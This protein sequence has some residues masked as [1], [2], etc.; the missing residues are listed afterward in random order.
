MNTSKKSVTTGDLNIKKC[1]LFHKSF[2]AS[3]YKSWGA[4]S[5]KV[6]NTNSKNTYATLPNITTL[7]E[8][9]LNDE[10]ETDSSFC[11]DNQWLQIS[12]H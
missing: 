2:S 8:D 4:I 9:V 7:P 5:G 6:E 3:R 1:F 11:Q 10:S 12:F